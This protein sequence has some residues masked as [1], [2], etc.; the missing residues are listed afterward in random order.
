MLID[1]GFNTLLNA[2]Y[3]GGGR[4]DSRYWPESM[5]RT[6]NALAADGEHTVP[7]I[8]LCHSGNRQRDQV[9]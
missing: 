6:K 7:T 8:T 5:N 9:T 2:G 3:R 1:F 4:I